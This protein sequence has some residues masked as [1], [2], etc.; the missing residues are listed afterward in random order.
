MI[1]RI[2]QHNDDATSMACKFLED[3][4]KWATEVN[5]GNA[6]YLRM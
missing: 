1:D 2:A 3:Y 4:T 6:E 5:F